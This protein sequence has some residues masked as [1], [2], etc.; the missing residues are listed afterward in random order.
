MDNLTD[1]KKDGFAL[2]YLK[3]GKLCSVLLNQAQADSLNLTL[4]VVFG[5]LPAR[6][7]K[8]DKEE[9]RKYFEEEQK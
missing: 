7:V 3:D 4:K 5:H 6:I 8:A 9:M 2:F 1:G